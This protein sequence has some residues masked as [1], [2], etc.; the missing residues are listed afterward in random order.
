MQFWALICSDVQGFESLQAHKQILM[1]N[2]RQDHLFCS[3]RDVRGSRAHLCG[4]QAVATENHWISDLASFHKMTR[5]TFDI[6]ALEDTVVLRI[7]HGEL[8]DLYIKA[9][10]F[11]RIFRVLLE[12]HFM[13]QQERI[14]QPSFDAHHNL[15]VMVM[16]STNEK[17]FF[18]VAE[19]YD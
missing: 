19:T 17:T 13:Q 4:M 6:D 7:S 3:S 12:N 10:K 16:E 11:D 18:E 15:I 8:I 9:R 14:G 5:S 1:S 2:G